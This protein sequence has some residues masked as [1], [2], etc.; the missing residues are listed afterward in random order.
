LRKIKAGPCAD[1]HSSGKTVAGVAAV[2]TRRRNIM[3]IPSGP[4]RAANRGQIHWTLLALGV[5]VLLVLAIV[6]GR[7]IVTILTID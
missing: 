2:P 3:R 1:G 7:A 5:G 6:V 4:A